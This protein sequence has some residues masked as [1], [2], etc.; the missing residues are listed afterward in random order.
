M[1]GCHATSRIGRQ[2]PA[3]PYIYTQSVFLYMETRAASARDVQAMDGDQ[4]RREGLQIVS[5]SQADRIK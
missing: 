2:R 3:Q 4:C 1:R 5:L